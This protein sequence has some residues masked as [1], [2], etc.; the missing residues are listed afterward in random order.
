[1]LQISKSRIQD[2]ILRGRHTVQMR[3]T[4]RC[5]LF[6]KGLFS[7][8]IW[9]SILIDILWSEVSAMPWQFTF[10]HKVHTSIGYLEGVVKREIRLLNLVAK[11]VAEL[12][13]CC[14][15]ISI[16]FNPLFPHVLLLKLDPT[17]IDYKLMHF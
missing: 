6:S 2:I 4:H 11:F 5:L 7:I 15:V 3:N 10:S 17:L 14:P 8:S 12:S 16:I 13:G 9:M 1:M